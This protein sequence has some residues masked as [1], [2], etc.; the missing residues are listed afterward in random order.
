MDIPSQTHGIPL[1]SSLAHSSHPG[2]ELRV[3]I[4]FTTTQIPGPPAGRARH[5]A[6]DFAVL[7]L[8]RNFT[9]DRDHIYYPSNFDSE[10]KIPLWMLVDFNI[11]DQISDIDSILT[12]YWK[13]GYD[14][15][16]ASFKKRDYK[17]ARFIRMFEW[18]GRAEEWEFRLKKRAE[19][20]GVRHR[21]GAD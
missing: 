10:E 21:E 7:N 17:G 5:I 3:A 11:K 15:E 1:E 20:A 4:R 8:G 2:I 16:T 9:W 13:V 6:D 12:Q 14:N 19:K 18:G